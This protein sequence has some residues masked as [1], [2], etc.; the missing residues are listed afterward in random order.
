MITTFKVTPF[1]IFASIV[2]VKRGKLTVNAGEISNSQVQQLDLFSLHSI[3]SV[4]KCIYGGHITMSNGIAT[5]YLK[6][7][8][9]DVSFTNAISEV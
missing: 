8:L 3:D 5:D 1:I 4:M 7:A 9:G 2:G 6:E